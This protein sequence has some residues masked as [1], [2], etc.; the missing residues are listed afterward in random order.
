[1]ERKFFIEKALRK[2]CPYLEL[3]WSAFSCIRTEYGEIVNLLSA[4]LYIWFML[5]NFP[6]IYPN[7]TRVLNHLVTTQIATTDFLEFSDRQISK[8]RKKDFWGKFREIHF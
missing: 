7:I 5:K 1:M 4:A 3:F 8:K 6:K 2:K